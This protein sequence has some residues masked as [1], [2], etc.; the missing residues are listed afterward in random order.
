MKYDPDRHH[1]RSIR[2]PAWNYTSAGTYFITIV[3]QDRIC[4]FETPTFRKIVEDEWAYLPFRFP[5]LELDAFIAMPNYVH[6][7]IWL[8]P[9]DPPVGAPCMAPSLG[10]IVRAFKAASSRR[11]RQA[12]ADAFAWQRNYYERII[13]NER[14][15]QATRQYIEDNP[16]NWAEDAENPARTLR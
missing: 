5:L 4:W 3:T 9:P 14:E 6:F 10:K 13:R 12:G 2:L 15:L 1:R 16:A 11:I 8:H 7:I